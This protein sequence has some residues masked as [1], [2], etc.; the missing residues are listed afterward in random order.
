MHQSTVMD[1]AAESSK[2]KDRSSNTDTSE[3][4]HTKKAREDKHRMDAYASV[5]TMCEFTSKI[6]NE[7]HETNKI[8][9]IKVELEKLKVQVEV[10]KTLGDQAQLRQLAEEIKKLTG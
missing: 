7:F 3:E 4:R 10:A 8:K 5:T 6:Y 2:D 1:P 9:K